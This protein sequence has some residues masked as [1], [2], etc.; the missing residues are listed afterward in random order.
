[1]AITLDGTT[2]ITT[3]DLTS[4]APMDVGGSAVLTAASSLAAANLTGSLPAIDG[5]AVTSLTSANL[6]GA[7]PSIDGSALTGV[8]STTFGDVGTYVTAMRNFP[9][10]TSYAGGTTVAGSN[11]LK[12]Q[13]TGQGNSGFPLKSDSTN[14][15]D[16]AASGLSGTW[17]L[18]APMQ[19]SGNSIK[20]IGGLYV[21]TV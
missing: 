16:T 2:G 5:S 9:I 1:M 12:W 21:R 8:G 20:V 7:L 10:N 15:N 13:D 6:T 4:A 19:S 14:V 3:P 17:R 11:L 18:M